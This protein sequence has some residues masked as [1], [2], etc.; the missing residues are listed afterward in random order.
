MFCI[1]QDFKDLDILVFIADSKGLDSLE[2][3]GPRQRVRLNDLLGTPLGPREIVKDREKRSPLY[4][5]EN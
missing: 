1:S 4:V 5:V 2:L 3:S